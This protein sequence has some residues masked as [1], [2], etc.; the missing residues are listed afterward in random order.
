MT[1][2]TI[3][4]IGLGHMG[5]PMVRNLLKQKFKVI[6]FDINP[7]AVNELV[8]EGA[9]TAASVKD[10]AKTADIIFTMLQ[11]GEQVELTCLGE[12][13]LFA[14]MSAKNL[15]IDCSSID[16]KTTLFLHEQAK[17][18]DIM[19]LDAPVSGGVAGAAAATLT[20]MVGGE[21]VAFT[22]AQP[23]LEKL[24]QRIIHAGR[25][26]HG[27]MAKICNN[28]IL[29]ISMIAV[30][31]A[32]TLAEK[33]GLSAEKLFEISSHASGQCW[34][35]THYCPVPGLVPNVPSNNNYQAGFTTQMML[36][37]L[38]LSQDAA[39]L[40]NATT[41]LGAEATALYAMFANQGFEQMDFSGIIKMIA[42][43]S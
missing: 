21:E 13:G 38:Y 15:L 36:K 6:V 27:Q 35:M 19:M 2:T 30:A 7:K 26:G 39:K 16:L 1:T 32:F 12:N 3:G 22:K 4:F 40:A 43:S 29:G 14:Y 31:E 28:M 41:P 25:A 42:G 5:T 18:A 34:S 37:D 23:I 33:L 8:D 17:A 11:T 24:G 9:N 20:I 10:I